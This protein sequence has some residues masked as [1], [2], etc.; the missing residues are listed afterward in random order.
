V[1]VYFW[2]TVLNLIVSIVE[3]NREVFALHF[4]RMADVPP[5]WKPDFQRN[6]LKFAPARRGNSGNNLLPIYAIHTDNPY[7]FIAQMLAS[8]ADV[9]STRC[10]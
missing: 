5:R 6:L 4:S 2:L 3:S 1:N 9:C 7:P 10:P 8:Y